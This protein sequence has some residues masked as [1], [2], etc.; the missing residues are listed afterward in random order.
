M[1]VSWTLT[2]IGRTQMH[3]S[4]LVR[5]AKQGS[6]QAEVSKNERLLLQGSKHED[7]MTKTVKECWNV[8]YELQRT[9]DETR[10]KGG[11]YA[12]LMGSDWTQV[13]ETQSGIRC[14]QTR[15]GQGRQDYQEPFYIWWYK[16]TLMNTSSNSNKWFLISKWFWIE[17]QLFRMN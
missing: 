9:G 8:S 2:Q 16:E 6:K 1:F 14:T 13:R 7:A 11:I 15:R 3:D 17:S 12:G 5:A 4:G 10:H